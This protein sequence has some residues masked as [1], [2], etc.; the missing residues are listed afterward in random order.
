MMD[1]S[2]NDKLPGGEGTS[3]L[4]GLKSDL[5]TGGMAQN[6]KGYVE[7]DNRPPVARLNKSA[8]GPTA[9]AMGP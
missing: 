9:G 4:A 3:K 6:L 8:R 5:S 2:T 7:K 1:E